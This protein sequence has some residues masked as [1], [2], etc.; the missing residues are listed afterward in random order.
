MFLTEE[1]LAR[2]E[3]RLVVTV[4]AA[5]ASAEPGWC[6]VCLHGCMPDVKRGRLTVGCLGCAARSFI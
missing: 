6:D 1:H 4:H 3:Q 5:Q 2:A